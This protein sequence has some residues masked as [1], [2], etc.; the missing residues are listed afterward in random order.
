MGLRSY[1]NLKALDMKHILLVTSQENNFTE[2]LD[3]LTGEETVEI[4]QAASSEEAI[5]G[6]SANTPDLVIIDEIVDGTPGLKIARDILMK[7]AMLNQV[8]VSSLSSEEFHEA[9]EGLGIM[10]QLTPKPDAAKA[11]KVLKILGQMP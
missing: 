11:K 1:S 7:N 8:L 6:L 9:S 3:G 10:A 4:V 2:F 5:A